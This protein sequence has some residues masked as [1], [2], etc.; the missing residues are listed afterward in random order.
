MP[1]INTLNSKLNPIHFGLIP[2]AAQ[3]QAQSISR[4]LLRSLKSD[5]HL[6]LLLSKLCELNREV[7]A[8]RRLAQQL[9]PAA[10]TV[11]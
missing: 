11:N 1:P 7:A 8:S 4:V 3:S 10:E 9:Q 2:R 5:F 6:E